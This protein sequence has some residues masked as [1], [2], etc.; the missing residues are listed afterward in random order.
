MHGKS[1]DFD[2]LEKAFRSTTNSLIKLECIER[3]PD[4]YL[5]I[6]KTWSKNSRIQKCFDLGPVKNW[7]PQLTWKLNEAISRK[8]WIKSKQIKAN[9]I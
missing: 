3:K 2:V 1:T 8:I 5:K 6:W 9:E 7:S 4:A